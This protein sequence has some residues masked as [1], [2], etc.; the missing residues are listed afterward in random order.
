[1]LVIRMITGVSV[2]RCTIRHSFSALICSSDNLITLVLLQAGKDGMIGEGTDG[3]GY[4]ISDRPH[5]VCVVLA[6]ASSLVLITPTHRL[7]NPY[8]P[9]AD[10]K[11]A[12]GLLPTSRN[13]RNAERI[14]SLCWRRE[15]YGALLCTATK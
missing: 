9:T 12:I 11:Y 2:G 6:M 14:G 15:E 3:D 4:A 8:F 13:R 10:E 1:M 7:S 5:E